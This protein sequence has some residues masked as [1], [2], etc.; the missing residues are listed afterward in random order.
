M[1]ELAPDTMQVFDR[2]AVRG[3]R[4]RA[5]GAFVAHN[6]LIREVAERLAERLND[7]TR[8]FPRA[9]DLGCHTGIMARVLAGHD[10]VQTL[11]QCDLAPEMAHLAAGT[12]AP[13]LAADEEALPFAA[14]SFDLVLSALSLHWVND[15]PGTLLQIRHMLK[16]DGLLL[17]AMLGGETLRELRA[18]LMEAE[19]LEEDGASPRV[20]P[21]A[22]V[23]DAGALLQRAGFAMPVI[24][25]D[26]I[27]VTYPNALALMRDLRGMAETNAVRT[28]R[29]SFTRRSTL[30]RAAALYEQK[31]ADAK[32]RIP[33]TFE[34]IYLTAWAPGPDQPKALRPGSARAR[35]ADALGAAERPA[36][37]KTGRS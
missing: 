8:S 1:A 12:G 9:L 25:K 31:F 35:L 24:D 4:A 14:A 33:A 16:P 20:S 10:Q 22:E 27:P 11:V 19:I 32:G 13:S 23:R 5:A 36:G 17:V 37:D 21:F 2:R 18:T 28:R 15:L 6:F 30:M 7:V 34:V 3:H 29:K 26:T